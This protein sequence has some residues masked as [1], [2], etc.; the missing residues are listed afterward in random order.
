MRWTPFTYPFN[1]TRQPAATVPCGLTKAGLPI[2][3]QIVGALYDDARVLHAA[4]AFERARPWPLPA[5]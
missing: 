2:G 4:R 5:V 1:L 3:L